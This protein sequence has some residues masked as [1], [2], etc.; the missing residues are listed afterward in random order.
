MHHYLKTFWNDFAKVKLAIIS[1]IMKTSFQSH[2]KYRKKCRP[3]DFILLAQISMLIRN[4]HTGH[5]GSY[6]DIT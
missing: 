6:V 2:Q 3:W 5:D 4:K 1:S